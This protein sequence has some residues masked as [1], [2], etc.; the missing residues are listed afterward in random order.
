MP[1]PVMVPFPETAVVS[2]YVVGAVWVNVPDTV[3]ASVIET[4][5]DGEVPEQAPPHEEKLYPL[6][7]VAVSVILVPVFTV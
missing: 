6:D 4:V 1:V 5:H 3:R 7:G 2:V